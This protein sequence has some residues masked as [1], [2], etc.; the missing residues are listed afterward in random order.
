LGTPYGVFELSEKIGV[1]PWYWW[2]DVPPRKSA[3]LYVKARTTQIG[4]PSVTYR[5]IFINDED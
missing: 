4:P 3:I 2:A 1:S 5:G